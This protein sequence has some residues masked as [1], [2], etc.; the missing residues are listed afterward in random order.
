VYAHPTAL[1]CK[2]YEWHHD[3]KVLT[4][5]CT[6]NYVKRC[7]NKGAVLSITES[8]ALDLYV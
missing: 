5:C 4:L 8:G 7:G 6:P 1:T 2:G 3:E